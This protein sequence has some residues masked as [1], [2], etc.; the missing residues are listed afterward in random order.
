MGRLIAFAERS[1]SEDARRS[2]TATG[3]GRDSAL[4]QPITAD[5]VCWIAAR[6]INRADRLPELKR[7]KLFMVKAG[8]LYFAVD[9][10]IYSPGERPGFVIDSSLRIIVSRFRL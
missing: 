3:S 1:I 9:W 4:V 10:A 6:V 5:S 8:K 2:S 7:R